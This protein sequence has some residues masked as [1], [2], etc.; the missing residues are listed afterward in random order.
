MSH[1]ISDLFLQNIQDFLRPQACCQMWLKLS[2][3]LKNHSGEQKDTLISATPLKNPDASS[4][5][6]KTTCAGL[7]TTASVQYKGRVE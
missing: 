6:R 2:N 7:G 1:L 4:V 3:G 5:R